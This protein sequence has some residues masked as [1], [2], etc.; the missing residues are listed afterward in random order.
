MLMQ[1]TEL[2]TIQCFGIPERL[3]EPPRFR[4]AV[5][6]AMVAFVGASRLVSYL[7]YTSINCI[8]NV[9]ARNDS[10]DSRGAVMRFLSQMHRDF[11]GSAPVA[12]ID[13]DARS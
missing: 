12:P 6:A 9:D 10:P 13:P 4:L 11:T 2:V 1:L 3:F 5:A 7:A 8:V